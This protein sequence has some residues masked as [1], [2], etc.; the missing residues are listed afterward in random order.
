MGV[1]SEGY[2]RTEEG[3]C[4]IQYKESTGQTPDVFDMF[5]DDAAGVA[6]SADCSVSYVYIPGLSGDGYAPLTITPEQLTAFISHQCGGIFTTD[7]STVPVALV[8]KK[9]Y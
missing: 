6:S 4:R 5:P 1:G 9:Y 3:S 2:R 8:C 7:E